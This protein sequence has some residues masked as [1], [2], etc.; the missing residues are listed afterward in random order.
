MNNSCYIFYELQMKGYGDTAYEDFRYLYGYNPNKEPK[1][2]FVGN[3][4]FD[5]GT[6][7]FTIEE[8]YYLTLHE[9]ESGCY[10]ISSDFSGVLVNGNACPCS[11]K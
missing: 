10:R 5:E 1:E 11:L 9:K 8:K 6:Q 2:W 7:T 4:E 3:W